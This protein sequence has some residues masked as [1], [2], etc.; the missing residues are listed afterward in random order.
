MRDMDLQTFIALQ[1]P[2]SLASLFGREFSLQ[3]YDRAHWCSIAVTIL[4][5]RLERVKMPVK[6]GYFEATKLQESAIY[7]FQFYES[8]QKC[9]ARHM[10]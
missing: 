4:L 9:G 7:I 1:F 3:M 8:N 5:G 2:P 6:I 10:R